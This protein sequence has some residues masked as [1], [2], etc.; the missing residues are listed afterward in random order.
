MF[1]GDAPEKPLPL[2][3]MIRITNSRHVCIWWSL[4]PPREPKDLLRCAHRSTNTEDSTPAPGALWF[5]PRDNQ[6]T[7]SDEEWPSSDEERNSD[8]HQP[9]SS[10]RP[11]SEPPH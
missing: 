5:D 11:Q 6:G 9:E 4:N 3:E 1:A 8:G 7:P 2:A 10:L